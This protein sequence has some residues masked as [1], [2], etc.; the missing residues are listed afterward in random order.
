MRNLP[1]LATLTITFIK[2]ICCLL[3]RPS[4]VFTSHMTHILAGIINNINMP[5]N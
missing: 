3:L 1:S 5:N 2:S 4:S